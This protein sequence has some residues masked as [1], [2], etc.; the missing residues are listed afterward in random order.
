MFLFIIYVIN[1]LVYFVYTLLFYK[2]SIKSW[3]F[4]IDRYS[5]LT[6]MI[7]QCQDC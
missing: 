4:S 2:S 5:K 7:L 3:S 6:A 1:V